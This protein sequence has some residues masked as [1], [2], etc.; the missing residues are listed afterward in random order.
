[1]GKQ[2][3]VLFCRSATTPQLAYQ[4]ERLKEYADANNCEVVAI[5]MDRRNGATARRWKLNLAMRIACKRS[6]GILV[7]D[8]SKVS[9]NPIMSVKFARQLH[10]QKIELFTTVDGVEKDQVETILLY[11]KFAGLESYPKL[12]MT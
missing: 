11:S 4:Q 12:S 9:R 1:M 7:T 8:I 2:K 6:A 3:V 10:R 5:V